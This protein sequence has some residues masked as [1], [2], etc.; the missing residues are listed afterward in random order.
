MSIPKPA[1]ADPV[2]APDC[3][4]SLL[5]PGPISVR[6]SMVPRPPKAGRE[7]GPGNEAAIDSPRGR[8]W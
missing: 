5:I 1:H 2:D 7:V 4:V 3:M 8:S 6:L